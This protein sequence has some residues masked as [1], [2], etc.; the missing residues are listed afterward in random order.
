MIDAFQLLGLILIVHLGTT[1]EFSIKES[2]PS[3]DFISYDQSVL[4]GWMLFLVCLLDR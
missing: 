1:M 4:G 2:L 3:D